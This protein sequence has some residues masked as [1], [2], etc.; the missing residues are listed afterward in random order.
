MENIYILAAQSN[1]FFIVWV[2]G[3][4][5]FFLKLYENIWIS[6]LFFWAKLS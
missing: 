4:E 2:H 1:F 5:K 6:M 3:M